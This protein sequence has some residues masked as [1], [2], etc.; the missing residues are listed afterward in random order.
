MDE[1]N[2]QHQQSN[3][4]PFSSQE[5]QSKNFDANSNNVQSN[6]SW[7]REDKTKKKNQNILQQSENDSN[8]NG[9]SIDT[10]KKMEIIE[11]IHNNDKQKIINSIN[12]AGNL[13]GDA[14][15]S[16]EIF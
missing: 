9:A 1:Q 6:L 16:G 10:S 14:L 8:R 15:F 13:K 5:F 2:L 4:E 11:S 7:S 3:N 12:V